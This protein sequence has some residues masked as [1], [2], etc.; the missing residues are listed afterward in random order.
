M[1]QP[2]TLATLRKNPAPIM[3]VF[4][5][6]MLAGYAVREPR[7]TVIDL[8]GSKLIQYH[9]EAPWLV[10]LKAAL[11]SAYESRIFFGGRGP[12]DFTSS[13]G[14]Y[15]NT[16]KGDF[17]KFSG[18]ECVVTDNHEYGEHVYGGGLLI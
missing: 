3:D 4:F 8:P 13:W 10:I 2:V 5:N 16:V 18:E 1:S 7:S 17:Q 14:W 15:K 11:V 9:K 6:A 12:Q